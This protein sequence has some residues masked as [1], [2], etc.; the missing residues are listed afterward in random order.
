MTNNR[1]LWLPDALRVAG[2]TV[3]EIPG[4]QDRGHTDD[5]MFLKYGFDPQAVVFHHDGSGFGD[6]P[7]ALAWLI[8]GF[9]SS[10]DTNFDAQC[11]VNRYGVWH[12]VAAG[13]AQHAGAGQGW[14]AIPAGMGNTRSF[15]VETDHTD[16]EPWP[17]AQLASVRIGM[18]AI[19]ADR[20]WDPARCVV[21]HKEYA[22]GRKTDPAGVDMD[23]F[24]AEVA[25]VMAKGWD[26]VSYDDVVRALRD[27]L[28]LPANG[29]A[30]PRGQVD[31][32]NLAAILVGMAQA[33][34][35]RDNAEAG[36][37]RALADQLDPGKLA[38]AV[39]AKLPAGGGVVPG[40][41][42]IKQAIRETF[43]EAFPATPASPT[44]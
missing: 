6:S 19:S 34:V 44:P 12:V 29:L 23:T 4:W 24:R 5:E 9:T 28:R 22:P 13:Y 17:P 30:V 7:G 43:A 2:L 27:V 35:N 31:N 15:G 26:D 8:S 25:A 41:A 36:Q 38:D 3:H 18:A 16:A 1:L 14:G 32:G 20:G 21:G 33:E 11:W 40:P 42:D 37:L 10:S 39:V